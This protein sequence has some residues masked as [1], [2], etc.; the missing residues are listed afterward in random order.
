MLLPTGNNESSAMQ[1]GLSGTFY[2][3]WW[4]VAASIVLLP[5]TLLLAFFSLRTIRQAPE[6][7]TGRRTVLV[8]VWARERAFSAFRKFFGRLPI[9]GLNFLH[10]EAC[11]SALL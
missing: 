2:F 11:D 1:R 6:V 8:S 10:G 3:G 7:W 4:A 5:L 9:A